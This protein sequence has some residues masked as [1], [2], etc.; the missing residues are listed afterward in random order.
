MELRP[1]QRHAIDWSWHYMTQ[2]PGNPCIVL[3]TGSGKSP[4]IATM[5]KE[6]LENWRG[7]TMVI[8]HVKELLQQ[9][10]D[11]LTQWYPE[12]DKGVYSAGM[13]ARCTNNDVIIGG[14]QSIYK[15]AG[16]FGRR[17]LLLIDEAHLIPEHEDGM[18]RK[19]IADMA[20]L[21]P[22]LKTVGLTATPYRTGAGEICGADRILNYISYKAEIGDLIK[23]GFL[24]NLQNRDAAFTVDMSSVGKT[25]GEF[26]S[27]QMEDAFNLHD[28]NTRASAQI[29]ECLKTRTAALVFCSGVKHGNRIT[30]ILTGLGIKTGFVWGDMTPLERVTTIESFKRGDLQCLV[31]VNVLT[32]GF[33]ATHIDL[34]AVLRATTSPGLFYQMCGRGFRLHPGK[35]D[36]LILDFGGNIERHGPLDAPDYGIAAIRAME[37]AKEEKRQAHLKTCPSCGEQV[38]IQT[39]TCPCG[40][41]FPPSMMPVDPDA[42]N[43]ILRADAAAAVPPPQW[44]DV[45]EV[46][47][48]EHRKKDWEEGDPVTLRV[49]YQWGTGLRDWPIREWVCFEHKGFAL[50]KAKAW[51]KRRS[52]APFPSNVSDA[53]YLIIGKKAIADTEAICVGRDPEN[54]KW[55]R[56]EDYKLGPLPEVQK[57]GADPERGCLVR[58]PDVTAGDYINDLD[59]PF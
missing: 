40:F 35:E 30:D 8:T 44:R 57:W 55:D 13:N 16:D 6:A 37:A 49:E 52:D 9:L 46:E 45:L 36:C 19:F 34:V 39:K 38:A 10:K 50:N 23:Q 43:P 12:I 11:T 59:I 33:D 15:R 3:P 4:V 20:A 41:E 17:H 54:P 29:A 47:Y 21:N 1:Y 42:A 18:Y 22:N 14:I 51:W 25:A 32:T 5:C 26:N 24:S 2:G 53:L 56:I 28:E 27:G 7:R 48:F 31:N 58:E